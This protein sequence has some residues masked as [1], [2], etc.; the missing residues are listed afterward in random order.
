MTMHRPAVATSTPDCHLSPGDRRAKITLG[1]SGGF[2]AK[3]LKIR[4]QKFQE[5]VIACTSSQKK[6]KNLILGRGLDFQKNT[7]PMAWRGVSIFYISISLF[8]ILKAKK[9]ITKLRLRQY[10]SSLSCRNRRNA[11]IEYWIFRAFSCYLLLKNKHY[12]QI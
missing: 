2:G 1:K 7:L 8:P 11:N 3:F 5:I 6:A 9:I 4:S 10:F 12:G